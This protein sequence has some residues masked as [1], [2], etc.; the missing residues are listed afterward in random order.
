MSVEADFGNN[1]FFP[2]AMV[3][4]GEQEFSDERQRFLKNPILIAEVLSKSTESYDKGEKFRLYRSIPSLKE[5]VLISS[6][7]PVV[8]SFYKEGDGLWRISSAITLESS[9]HLYALNIDIP[10]AQIYA[11]VTGLKEPNDD[12]PF[13]HSRT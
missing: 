5:Y 11:K 12:L 10:L 1:Y 2:D 3:T 13:L 9:I 8:E 4:F 6:D 7:R